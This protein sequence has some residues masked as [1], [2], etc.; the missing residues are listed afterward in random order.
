VPPALA[1]KARPR[2]RGLELSGV[3]GGR[4][5]LLARIDDGQSRYAALLTV[6]RRGTSW[7]V[8]QV[9]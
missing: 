5:I 9:R 7:A 1:E 6:Q 2:L 4:V 8:S 3:A